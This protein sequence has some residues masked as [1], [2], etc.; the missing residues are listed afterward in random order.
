MYG[1]S[2]SDLS[3]M[4][5]TRAPQASLTRQDE[6]QAWYLQVWP[7]DE[8]NDII[9]DPSPV[10]MV[11]GLAP[12]EEEEELETTAAPDPIVPQLQACETANIVLRTTQAGDRYFLTWDAVPGA[13]SY[14]IYRA[15]QPPT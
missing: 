9:G 2:S 8:N 1:I 6:T 14:I 7:V 12:L 10:S 3:Q 11:A 15:E 13:T 4:I 5:T